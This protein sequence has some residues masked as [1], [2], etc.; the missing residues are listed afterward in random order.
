MIKQFLEDYPPYKVYRD[1]TVPG[2]VS[3]LK[4]VAINMPCLV[5]KSS[6]TYVMTNQYA[7]HGRAGEYTANKIF[8]LV[9]AC[10]HCESHR[11]EFYVRADKDNYVAKVGQYPPWDVKGNQGIERLLGEHA[12]YY[13]RGLICESQGFGIGAFGYYRRIVEETIDALLT[14]IA[15]LMTGD[16]RTRYEGVLA[17]VATTR[18]TQEKIDLVKD[19]LPP[20]LVP[21]GMNPL[22]VLHSSLSEGLHAE[23]DEACLQTAGA[24][25]EVLTFLVHQIAISGSAKKSFTASMR[26][27]LEKKDPPKEEKGE[28]TKG[29]G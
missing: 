6:Q 22:G 18:V 20:I 27:L 14:Q 8:R 21:D 9:Y 16:E 1:D 4:K 3:T 2:N 12:V 26:K 5:C 23:S 13:R 7:E 10:T 19:L 17:K 29:G 15:D 24:V 25:R 28:E 11:R